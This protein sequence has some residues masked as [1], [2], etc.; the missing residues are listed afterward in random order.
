MENE[1][2]NRCIIF[3]YVPIAGTNE[4]KK[5]ICAESVGLL[6]NCIVIFFFFLYCNLAIVLQ[7]RGLEKKN[8]LQYTILYCR[9]GGLRAEFVLQYYIVL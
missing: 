5:K 6:P 4:K 3:F 1:K 9:E 8:V 2:K 7:E